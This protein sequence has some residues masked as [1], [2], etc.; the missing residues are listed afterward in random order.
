MDVL[1]PFQMFVETRIH[2]KKPS[3]LSYFFPR[4]MHH[5]QSEFTG[6]SVHPKRL[7]HVP[8]VPAILLVGFVPRVLDNSELVRIYDMTGS[9]H[10]SDLIS[11]IKAPEPSLKYTPSSGPRASIY[12]FRLLQD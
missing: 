4:L 7:G 9:S 2:R 3:K 12:P 5:R 6:N 11:P 1:S 10:L 8:A